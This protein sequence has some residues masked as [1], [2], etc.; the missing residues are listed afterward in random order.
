[1]H[2]AA[3][4]GDELIVKYLYQM[5]ANPNIIDKVTLT[6]VRSHAAAHTVVVATTATR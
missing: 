1:M 3:S 5:K 4:E 2:V 6:S